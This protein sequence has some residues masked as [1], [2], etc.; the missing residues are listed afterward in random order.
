MFEDFSL[1]PHSASTVS[2]RVD[3][4]YFAL[5]GISAFFGLGI[6]ATLI[7]FAVRY[8]RRPGW[9][10]R[11]AESATLE[12]LWAGVPL[13]IVLGIFGWSSA[14]YFDVRTPPA[15][16]MQYYATGKQWMWKIQH[17]T[18]QRE[19]NSLHVP[20]GQRVVVTLTSE[21][22]I[23]SFYL[24]AFRVKMDAVPGMYTSLWFEPTRAGTYHL[25]CAEYCGTKHSDM[26]GSVVV[27]EPGDYQTWLSRQP[28]GQDPVEAGR[29][30]FENLA[31]QSCHDVDSGQRGPDLRNRYGTQV[32]T[33]DGQSVLFDEDYV[34]ESILEPSRRI[35]AGFQPVMPSYRGQV[36]EDQILQIIAYL[37]SIAAGPA[38]SETSP[39]EGEQ[40]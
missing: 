35:T 40:R 25:F 10:A 34:R 26:I 38:A 27:M 19:I 29:V 12:V 23:H 5:V 4:L 24:P 3:A 16:G 2:G 7:F 11:P 36:D 22:V 15:A 9:V 39:Q 37:K 32:R 13:L 20:L 33:A 14:L 30:L 21:D 18:G 31:C 17:P 1:F 28:T 8:R 6:A